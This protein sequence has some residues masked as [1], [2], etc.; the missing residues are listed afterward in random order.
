M[1]TLYLLLASLGLIALGVAAGYS[2]LALTAVLAWRRRGKPGD[3]A[4]L[5]GVTVLK[6]LCG[7]EPRLYE[8][9]RSFCEQDYPQFQLIFGVREASDPALAVVARLQAEFPAL[10]IEVVV[11]PEQHGCNRKVSN[12]LNMLAHARHG[13]LAMADSDAFVKPDYLA[14]VTRP[15]LDPRVGLVTCVFWDAPTERVWSRLGAMYVNEWYMPSVLFAWL[16]GHASYASGQTLCI[17][18]DTLEA[19]GGLHRIVDYLAEDNRLGELVRAQGQR[20]VLSDYLLRTARDEPT[21]GL[22]T[23]H[24]LRWMRTL[25]VLRP[26]S[27]RMLFLTF[28]VP[29]ALLGAALAAGQPGFAPLTWALLVAVL[30]ARLGLYLAHR[31]PGE[32]PLLADLW[33]VPVR[34]LLILWVWL[35]SFFTSRLIWRGTE[36]AV[37]TDGIMR[38]LS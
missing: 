3:P 9:L 23:G 27:F 15:L 6:P 1:A 13:V 5:P 24:E 16:F 35:R 10:P 8:N 22:L 37:G 29:L 2:V 31:R 34:D 14:T 30:A 36:F 20:I 12:L 32:R 4:G 18:R 25:K 33:L 19:I 28:S 17:R 7:T 38:E 21:L 26:S 11:N